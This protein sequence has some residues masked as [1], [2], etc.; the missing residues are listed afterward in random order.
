MTYPG[1]DL[2]PGALVQALALGDRQAARGRRQGG[3]KGGKTARPPGGEGK[4]EGR[5]G[6]DVDAERDVRRTNLPVENVFPDDDD[7]PG[8][9]GTVIGYRVW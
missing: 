3:G 5:E 7:I 8:S 1:H 2:A 6:W 4:E 9:R